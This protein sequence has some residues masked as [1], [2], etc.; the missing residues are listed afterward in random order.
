MIIGVMAI[1]TVKMRVMNH[2][3]VVCVLSIILNLKKNCSKI[4]STLSTLAVT[5]PKLV[6]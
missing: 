2:Q 1:L 5:K 4:A 3:A 6:Y